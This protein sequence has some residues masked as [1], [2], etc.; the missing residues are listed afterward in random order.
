MNLIFVSGAKPGDYHNAINGRILSVGC[1][2]K[3]QRNF[4]YHIGQCF[5]LQCAS[6]ETSSTELEKGKDNCLGARREN[7]LPSRIFQS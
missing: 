5:T 3:F 1:L 6:G 7:S 2:P 4:I